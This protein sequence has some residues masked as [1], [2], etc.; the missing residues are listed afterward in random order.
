[1]LVWGGQGSQSDELQRMA[2]ARY[3]PATD[4]WW[5]MAI[6]GAPTFRWNPTTVWT[7]EEMIVWGGELAGIFYN[8]VDANYRYNPIADQ[9][10]PISED[11]APPRCQS[12]FG[13]WTGSEMIVWPGRPAEDGELG[14]GRY[15]P[16]TDTWLPVST[17]GAPRYGT[18]YA[19]VW[20]GSGMIVW[21][22]PGS[23]T[24][25]ESAGMQY[26]PTTDVWT[27]ISMQ[28]APVAD[29]AQTAVWTGQQ[30]IIWGNQASSDVAY[31]GRYDPT[32]DSWRP[33]SRANGPL[34]RIQ[35]TTVWTGREMIVWGGRFHG[36]AIPPDHTESG[37]RYDPTSDTWTTMPLVGAPLKRGEHS[38][39]W[40]DG[41]MI[42]LGGM[43]SYT[44]LRSGGTFV[45]EQTEDN[46]GDG[47]SECE[48]DCNDSNPDQ[49][50]G[51]SEIFN[52]LDD[53]CD[54][55][56]DEVDSDSDGVD[57]PM[58]NCAEVANGAQEDFDDDGVGDTCEV[59]PILADVDN[60]GFV[61][62]FDL[63]RVALA[64]GSACRE[65]RYQASADLDRN[66]L[67]DGV[68]LII[69]ARYF[70]EHID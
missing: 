70:G 2:G 26:D 56:A 57:D 39:T 60:S 46:D 36:M 67:V 40:C 13:V 5:P 55:W 20:T 17:A 1:L 49:H 64:F 47:F 32:T 34:G 51:V 18:G 21:G 69:L 3:D 23:G 52:L 22:A 68:D 61:D 42:V 58:D 14:A 30:M 12:A 44:P 59:G 45:L 27:P 10:L 33:I 62:G 11:G 15:D 66:C 41:A 19:A 63:F 4:T 54:G 38:A 24:Y 48:G 25:P 28:D 29:S 8:R 9:W 65:P 43:S 16:T 31:G 6:E 7:G 35:H 50:P 53:D 37:A